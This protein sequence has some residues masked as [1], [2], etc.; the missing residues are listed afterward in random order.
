MEYNIA[1]YMIK[2][3]TS[4]LN[5]MDKFH[6]M[7]KNQARWYILYYSIYIKYKFNN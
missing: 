7:R 2:Q 3:F 5:N 6:K 1:I 4:V